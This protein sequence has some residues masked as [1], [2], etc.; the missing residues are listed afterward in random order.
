[1]IALTVLNTPRADVV[2][3]P[4]AQLIKHKA[5]ELRNAAA[6]GSASVVSELLTLP[7]A[8][9][10]LDQPIGEQATTALMAAAKA[11]HVDV[12]LLLLRAG[13]DVN[14]A[15]AAGRTALMLAAAAGEAS[16]FAPLLENGADTAMKA[17]NGCTALLFACGADAAGVTDGGASASSSYGRHE[18]VE[19]Y[20]ELCE[21]R[22]QPPG[23]MELQAAMGVVR[24]HKCGSLVRLIES[25]LEDETGAFTPR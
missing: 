18:A 2:T 1:M 13:A 6:Y 11:G 23:D 20:L 5:E 24:R 14:M 25:R 12:A 9:S 15:D 3:D 22:G 21:A 16:L 7:Q 4:C 10:I 19:R 8:G 17:A